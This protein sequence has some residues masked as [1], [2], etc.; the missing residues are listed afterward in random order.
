VTDR[1]QRQKAQEQAKREAARKA[2]SRRE[3]LKRLGIA[4]GLGLL[5]VAFLLVQNVLAGRDPQQPAAYQ[6]FL[7][8]EVACGSTAPEEQTT[9]RWSEPADQALEGPVSAVVETS[10]GSFTIELDPALAP[11]SVNDFVFLARQGAYDGTVFH[12]S[13]PG[14]WVQAGDPAANG[15]GSL[16]AG[17][18][19]PDEFPGESFSMDRGVVGLVGDTATRGSTFFVVT[20]EE[21]PI[22]SRVNVIGEVIEGLDV[23]DTIEA[24][25]TRGTLPAETVFVES[26]TIPEG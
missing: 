18:R 9:E 14:I 19:V 13:S 22:S 26:V 3:L 2:A 21:A 23:I 11:T 20:G 15:G 17:Y 24:I 5:V 6:R 8:Q 12:L 1:R 25:P 16:F 10:C 7:G 4:F